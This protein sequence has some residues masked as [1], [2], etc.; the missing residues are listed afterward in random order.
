[1][2]TPVINLRLPAWV[3]CFLADSPKLFP[4]IDDR[5]RFVLELARRNVQH[6]TGGPFGAAVFD[7]DGQLIAPGINLVVISNCSLLHAEMV[8]LAGAQQKL[9]RY[10]I[11]GGG[12]LHYDLFATTEPCAMCFGAIPW[13]GVRRLVCGA[14]DEDARAIGFDEGPKLADWMAALNDRGITVIRD[15]L[16]DEAAAVLQDYISAGGIIYNTGH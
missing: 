9:G 1:M 5:M 14:R 12:R 3:E 16:R 7:R 6:G 15:V 10:D 11:G 8:A 4:K 13:S 2:I